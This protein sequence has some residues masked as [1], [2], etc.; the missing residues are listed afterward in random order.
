MC[1]EESRRQPSLF[2]SLVVTR[3]VRSNPLTLVLTF[4]FLLTS[5]SGLNWAILVTTSNFK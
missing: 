1:L 4:I 3:V 5:M 2:K